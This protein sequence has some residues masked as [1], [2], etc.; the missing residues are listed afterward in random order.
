MTPTQLF[1]MQEKGKI[2]ISL[3]ISLQHILPNNETVALQV[4]KAIDKTRNLLEGMFPLNE[5]KALMKRLEKL[6]DNIKH[7]Y[8]QQGIGIYIIHDGPGTLVQFPFA[9]KDNIHIGKSFWIKEILHLDYY[10][11]EYYVLEISQKI[12]RLY[13]GKLNNIQEVHDSRFPHVMEGNEY[14]IPVLNYAINNNTIEKD[15][16]IL[17]H[18]RMEIALQAIDHKLSHYLRE[19]P[20][21]VAGP[22]KQLLLF[23]KITNHWPHIVGNVTGNFR[24]DPLSVL[25]E[26]VWPE[27]KDWL[28][29]R[30]EVVANEWLEKRALHKICGIRNIW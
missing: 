27:I 4:K 25:E 19:Y 11:V 3:I 16:P 12:T 13:K 26:N 17:Q 6:T 18:K 20:L 22:E 24:N 2:C 1:H 28:N 9:V 15:K 5:M 29:R 30:K 23:N 7:E 8:D 14:A 10:K 21:V